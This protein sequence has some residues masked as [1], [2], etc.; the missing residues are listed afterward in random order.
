MTNAARQCQDASS[1]AK[2][3]T[4]F[5]ER[6]PYPPPVVDLDR[7]GKR[8]TDERRCADYHLF[9]PSKRYRDDFTILIAGCGTSQAAKYA[10]RWP[11]AKVT[12]IDVSA[13]SI[14]HTDALKKKYKLDNLTVVQLPV[15]QA[16]ELGRQFDL[17]VSTGVLHHLPDP[18]S[19]LRALRGVLSPDGAMQLMV[20]APYGRAGVYLLQDYCRRL[21]IGTSSRE[22][23]ELTQSLQG[24]PPD[25]P[26]VPLLR[27]A[28]DF[29]AEAG[30]ADALLHPQDRAYSV[31]EFLHFLSEADLKLGRWVRQA[32]YL[33]QCG[34]LA[35]SPHNALLERLPLSE[36]YAAIEDFR[37]TMVRHSAVIYRND[38]SKDQI[39][40]FT[41]SDWLDYVPMKQSDTIA[42]Q[43]KLP[44]GSAAVLINRSHTYTDIYLPITQ[45]QKALYDQIDGKQSIRTIIGRISGN[46]HNDTLRENVRRFFEQLWRYDQIV[47]DDSQT[48]RGTG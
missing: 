23:Q 6:H 13:N 42:V 26:L 5:Y 48:S 18:D 20:Y 37:G 24:L 33:P 30:I 47:I 38:Q 15:E 41:G 7:Y 16:T 2:L 8:W 44:A 21:G 32:A 10:L 11:K 39:V 27:H 14:H 46:T 40:S 17:V 22:I 31:P 34:A 43:D 1:T 28:P 3:V 12:G 4:D 19:G 35:S 29:K 45:A 36:Q 25:H 9:W